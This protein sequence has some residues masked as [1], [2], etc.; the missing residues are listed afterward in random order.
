MHLI[1]VIYYDMYIMICNIIIKRLYN[2]IKKIYKN[3]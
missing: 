3:I 1:Y 2:L